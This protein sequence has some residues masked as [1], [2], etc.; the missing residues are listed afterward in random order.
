MVVIGNFTHTFIPEL[1]NSTDTVQVTETNGI[2][3]YHTPDGIFPSVTTVVGYEN[4]KKF[5]K[6]R[7][8]N[9]KESKRV[10][11]RGTQ[12]H[13]TI[14]SYLL[15]DHIDIT[16]STASSALFGLIKPEVDKISDVYAIE[17]F[18]W[19]KTV[20]LAGRVDCIA[21]Y[22]G[23]PSVIDFKASTYPKKKEDIG[24]YFCQ[25]TA[26]SLMLQERTGIQIP[27]I[28]LLIANEQGFVQVF[29]EKVLNFIKPLKYSIDTYHKE[30]T[31]NEFIQE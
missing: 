2:R 21:R 11:D 7:E 14:E 12:L 22:K 18:L 26:Y 6:W 4:R 3:Q 23:I 10:C 15:N 25:A 29:Q 24:N 19:G 9:A 8:Q 20:G 17:T 28:V 5:K 30:V 31:N 1:Y 13:S 16:A 27:N